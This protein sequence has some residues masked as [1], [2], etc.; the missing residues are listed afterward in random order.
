MRLLKKAA[1][2]QKEHTYEAGTELH[3]WE[4]N[5]G[6]FAAGALIGALTHFLLGF[7]YLGVGAV[8]IGLAGVWEAYEYAYGIRPW[9][10][11]DGWTFDRAIEDT[12]LD[13]YVGL[14]GALL[15]VLVL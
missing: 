12:L 1:E 4:D 6:H 10:E 5:A 3:W 14:T 7:G 8:F 11:A 13:T 15:S 2:L 9:D